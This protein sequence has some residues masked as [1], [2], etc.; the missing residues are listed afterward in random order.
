[1]EQSPDG[2]V[3]IRISRSLYERAETEVGPLLMGMGEA[4]RFLGVS[5]A[6]L[7]RR[8]KLG[9]LERI[10]F[11]PNSYRVRRADLLAIV[12]ERKQIQPASTHRD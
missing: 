9:L 2:S 4:A 11:L 7:W 12:A 6:T 8:I 1:M 3:L 10:E 5:R